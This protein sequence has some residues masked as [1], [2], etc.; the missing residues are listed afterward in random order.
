[1]LRCVRQYLIGDF[2]WSDPGYNSSKEEIEARKRMISWRA[3]PFNK[4][5]SQPMF[6]DWVL[7][8]KIQ[9]LAHLSRSRDCFWISKPWL[10]IRCV[11]SPYCNAGDGSK[12]NKAQTVRVLKNKTPNSSFK[13][14]WEL[15]TGSLV[16]VA[17]V[18]C[19]KLYF[20]CLSVS[21]TLSI[22]SWS[23]LTWTRTTL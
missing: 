4:P 17:C 15:Q 5:I 12:N 1:M 23:I 20:R 21:K 19:V 9:I 18:R 11:K 8:E 6:P 13:S 3:I 7:K 10:P 14:P 16:L 22:T 2:Q